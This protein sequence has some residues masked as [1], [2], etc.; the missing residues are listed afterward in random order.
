MSSS[1]PVPQNA[2]QRREKVLL[3]GKALL[4]SS[5]DAAA[6]KYKSATGS[7]GVFVYNDAYYALQ[8]Q[9][10]LL[11]QGD[12]D[13][14][15]QDI[16]I[17]EK[18]ITLLYVRQELQTAATSGKTQ[19]ELPSS[20]DMK[21]SALA[22]SEKI[23]D[24][25]QTK[26][27][28]DKK[29]AE[30]AK[31]TAKQTANDEAKE[32][33]KRRLQEAEDKKERVINA[34]LSPMALA[35]KVTTERKDIDEIKEAEKRVTKFLKEH[36]DE[37]MYAKLFSVDNA[38]RH[39]ALEIAKFAINN[40]D[41]EWNVG[42]YKPGLDVSTDDLIKIVKMAGSISADR[43]TK[44]Q[45]QVGFSPAAEDDLTRALDPKAQEELASVMKQDKITPDDGRTLVTYRTKDQ[46]APER[47]V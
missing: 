32:A 42:W 46:A 31:E 2:A 40:S 45:N 15:K 38:S 37:K 9:I 11:K 14:K 1:I 28:K 44:K 20:S 29:L 6:A 34:K 12:N 5:F 43:E 27:D 35:I 24:E 7:G 30:E 47:K 10:E 22:I 41:K 25:R 21:D 26:I 23:F 18:A 13:T 8:S 3:L 36:L 39:E 4:G 17:L 16:D 33:E 19:I